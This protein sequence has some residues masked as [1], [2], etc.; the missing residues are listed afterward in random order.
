MA[1][2]QSIVSDSH[3]SQKIFLIIFLVSMYI[4]VCEPLRALPLVSPCR[5]RWTPPPWLARRHPPSFRL[6]PRPY[7]YPWPC[8]RRG[9]GRGWSSGGCSSCG[10][11]CRPACGPCPASCPCCCRGGGPCSSPSSCRDRGCRG[12]CGR[13]CRR[14]GC[15]S[16]GP[17]SRHLEGCAMIS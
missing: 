14:A 13:G 8:R 9:R 11:R 10:R 7:P 2:T 16:F 1:R 5:R 17:W 3:T 6:V 4:P 12:V 15:A